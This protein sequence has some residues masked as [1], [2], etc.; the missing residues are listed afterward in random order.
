MFMTVGTV[1]VTRNLISLFFHPLWISANCIS[2][3]SGTYLIPADDQ[4]MYDVFFFF[5]LPLSTF[6][7][8]VVSSGSRQPPPSDRIM[9]SVAAENTTIQIPSN[10]LFPHSDELKVFFFCEECQHRY[11]SH[12]DHVQMTCSVLQQLAGWM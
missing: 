7:S 5:S 4:R 10:H 1:Q 3:Q 11:V 9:C 6:T 12:F 2:P 8:P